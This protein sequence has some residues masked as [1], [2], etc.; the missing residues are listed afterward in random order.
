[1][2]ENDDSREIQ[3]YSNSISLNRLRQESLQTTTQS[4]GLIEESSNEVQS[5]SSDPNQ[6]GNQ[7][8]LQSSNKNNFSVRNLENEEVVGMTPTR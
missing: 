6:Y 4:L 7:Q 8:E 3:F 1:M 5:S 2:P